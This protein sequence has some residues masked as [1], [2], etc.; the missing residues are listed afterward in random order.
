MK[1]VLLYATRPTQHTS[2]KL[3]LRNPP[4]GYKFIVPR[5]RKKNIFKILSSSET[6]KKFYKNFIKPFFNTYFIYKKLNAPSVPCDSDLLFSTGS[7][8]NEKRPWVIE[9]LDH[10]ASMSG[11]SY[12]LFLKEIPVL[13]KKLLS[14]YC[15]KIIIVNEASLNIMEKHFSKEVTKK[16]ELV[17]AAV[18]KQTFKK[19]YFKKKIEILFMGSIANPDDFYMKGGLEALAAFSKVSEEYSN[20]H[21]TAA[22]KIPGEVKKVYKDKRNIDFLEESPPQPVWKQMQ[23]D[24]DIGLQPGHIYPLM[25]C[26]E[27][28]SMGT[29]VIMLDT[30]GVR[31]YL[32]NEEDSILINPSEKITSYKDLEYPLN[33]RGKKFMREIKNTDKRVVEDIVVALRRL[34]EDGNLRKRLGEKGRKNAS[35]KFSLKKRKE[36]L[37]DIFD[38]A[39]K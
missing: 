32:D 25:G 10:P 8:L 27:P 1:K 37:K 17:R 3:M 2:L 7:L 21:L 36:K 12:S 33:V 9:I 6:V 39:I 28:L 26:L 18:D 35:E 20:I 19:D 5:D 34:I 24:T 23:R 29:P 31:D 4:S 13:E 38:N 14:N 22:C 11:Y 30:W 16:C 15:K